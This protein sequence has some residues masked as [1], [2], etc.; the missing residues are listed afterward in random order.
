[1]AKVL[2]KHQNTPTFFIYMIDVLDIAGS[3]KK[4]VF[5]TLIQA[6][7]D[8]CIVVN[9]LDI[10]NEKYLNRHMI[11]DAVRQRMFDFVEKDKRDELKD[12]IGT[13]KIILASSIDRRGIKVLEEHLDSKLIKRMQLIGFPNT[14]KTTLLNQLGRTN[15][16][17]S[18]F[19][20]TT[21]YINE[22]F[23]KKYLIYDM[24]G[25]NSQ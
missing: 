24:P 14:G 20:G 9:K 1:M 21:L 10:V 4:Y 18:K 15:K 5:N 8:F 6:N 11:L 13:I 7:V 3:F 17:T 23:N 16:P 22:H 25:M 19:P 12:K 2:K